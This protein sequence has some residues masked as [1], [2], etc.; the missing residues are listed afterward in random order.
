MRSGGKL[1]TQNAECQPLDKWK[2]SRDAGREPRRNVHI[3]LTKRFLT[4]FEPANNVAAS[5]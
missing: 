3:P 5:L 1:G 4:T 2:A